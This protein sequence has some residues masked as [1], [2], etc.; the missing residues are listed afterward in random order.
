[1]TSSRGV[2]LPVRKGANFMGS[3]KNGRTLT[4]TGGRER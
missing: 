2:L 4:V 3:K 1:M